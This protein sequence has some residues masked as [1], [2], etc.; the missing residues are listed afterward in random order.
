MPMRSGISIYKEIRA[1]ESFK[2]LPI[3]LIS[4]M[5]G[6]S[7]FMEKGFRVL[8]TDHGV[9][10]PDGFFE[11]PIDINILIQQI[12]ELLNRKQ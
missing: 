3:I 11:K 12:N 4:G 8:V 2:H 5:A 10:P 7:D 9:P 6:A 1:S